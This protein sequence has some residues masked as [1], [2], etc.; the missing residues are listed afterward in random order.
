MDPAAVGREVADWVDD[1]LEARPI[2]GLHRD[3]RDRIR[4]FATALAAWGAKTNLTAK[5][6]NPLEVAFHLGDSITPLALSRSG[7]AG[8]LSGAFG[9]GKSVLDVGSGAGFPGLVL[10]AATEASFTLVES[11]QKRASF[12]RAV[13][14][15]MGLRNVRIETR[16]ISP[17][18]F[19]GECDVVM[20]R[21]LGQ[22]EVFFA[23]AGLAL[24][25]SGVAIIYASAAQ[26][27]DQETAQRAGLNEYFRYA[28]ELQRGYDALQRAILVWRK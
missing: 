18:D 22:P 23:I 20:T 26:R 3:F 5:P 6:D 11:R 25:A 12:L 21:A 14:A 17:G 16:R 1:W 19:A 24:R 7:N 9:E 4:V 13:S 2:A 10:A 28:F 8:V 27:I 15:E